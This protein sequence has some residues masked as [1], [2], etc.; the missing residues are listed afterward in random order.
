MTKRQKD[1]PGAAVRSGDDTFAR[2][3]KSA[4]KAPQLGTREVGAKTRTR[5]PQDK[6]EARS[7]PEIAGAEGEGDAG[8][9]VPRKAKQGVGRKELPP[10]CLPK[11]SPGG[12]RNGPRVALPTVPLPV[13]RG[14]PAGTVAASP[15]ATAIQG[16]PVKRVRLAEALRSSGLDELT[17]AQNYVVV[18]EKLRDERGGTD[19]TRKMLV[20]VLKEC[21]RILEPPK[22]VG[23]AS[24]APAVVNLYHNVP[25]PV[26]DLQRD[27][28]QPSEQ[29]E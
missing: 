18:V 29:S 23:G 12:L 25:R 3:A 13:F 15:A 27:A 19:G 5:V 22:S 14:V 8:E 11:A 20:D 28:T 9:R 4:E 17:V 1:E 24:E 7:A 10:G 16:T 26:R 21:S 2:L 6:R